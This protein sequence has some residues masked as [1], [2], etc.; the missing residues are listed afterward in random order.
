MKW[1]RIV[2]LI[3]LAGC[4]QGIGFQVFAY[5]TEV[6]AGFQRVDFVKQISEAAIVSSD[7]SGIRVTPNLRALDG[8]RIYVKGRMYP[9]PRTEGLD[10][11]FLITPKKAEELCVALMMNDVIKVKMANG[12]TANYTND[13]IAVAGIFRLR[14]PN[15]IRRFEHAFELEATYIG[16]PKTSY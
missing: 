1:R 4:L 8:K 14:D 9:P 5:M 2:A 10:D 11:F 3:C 7:G 13:L 15:Q 6:P 12:M 16:P